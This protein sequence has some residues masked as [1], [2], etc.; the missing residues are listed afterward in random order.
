MSIEV[1]SLSRVSFRYNAI[2]VLSDI[3][4]SVRRGDYIA[5]VG[6]NGSGKT[7]LIRAILG[8]ETPQSGE[9]RLFGEPAGRFADW[10]RIGYLPQRIAALNPRFPATVGEVVAMGLLSQKKFPKFLNRSDQQQID[11]TLQLL[12]MEDLRDEPI[13]TLSGGQQQ[14]ALVAR[15]IVNHPEFL[16]LDEPT[17]ALD[18]EVR[19]RFFSLLEHLNRKTQATIMIVTHDV[20]NI[21]QYASKLLYIDK[22]LLFYGTFE[23]FCESPDIT[24][25]F[26]NFSQH[27][28]CHRHDV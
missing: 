11:E 17:A 16:I 25:L 4:F 12:E 22:R 28:I 26:G 8:L 5:L 23:E 13:G 10:K 9:I 15:A 1:L 19:E 18:P 2:D 21:G 7:T 3:T 27:V 6:P 14:R 20:G 24:K